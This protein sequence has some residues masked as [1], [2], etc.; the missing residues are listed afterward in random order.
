MG[1]G[2]EIMATGFAKIEREKFPDR[3]IVIGNF[4]EKT[5]AQ[6][7]IFLNNS[8]LDNIFCSLSTFV[9]FKNLS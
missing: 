7:I 9:F 3:Q 6:S 4:E 8:Y 1:Y 2:D 5:A